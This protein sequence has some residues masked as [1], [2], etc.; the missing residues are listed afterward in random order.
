MVKRENSSE[1][2]NGGRNGERERRVIGTR[3]RT[4]KRGKHKGRREEEGD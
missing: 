2:T 3:R 4:E 1:E